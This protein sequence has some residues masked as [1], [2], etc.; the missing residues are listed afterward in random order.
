[1]KR[2]CFLA[3]SS[4][5]YVD[6]QIEIKLDGLGCES[7]RLLVE[8]LVI[9]RPQKAELIEKVY[10]SIG[11]EHKVGHIT[12]LSAVLMLDVID[13]LLF[14]SLSSGLPAKEDPYQQPELH[15]R[16][17]HSRQNY[18]LGR[19]EAERLE[20]RRD[21]TATLG[22]PTLPPLSFPKSPGEVF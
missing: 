1:M 15:A 3:Q 14:S 9:E 21:P 12:S 11:F 8:N 16:W 10:F 19:N 5:S 7:A 22:C 6:E 20:L 18:L 17:H 13:R 4:F 2:V